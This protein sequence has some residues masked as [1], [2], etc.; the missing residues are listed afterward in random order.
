MTPSLTL[1]F[2]ESPPDQPIFDSNIEHRYVSGSSIE[3]QHSSPMP[4]PGSAAQTELYKIFPSPGDLPAGTIPD[5]PGP[6]QRAFDRDPA[7]HVHW[8][9]ASPTS[10][11]GCVPSAPVLTPL[12]GTTLTLEDFNPAF[13]AL[14]P[15]VASSIVQIGQE[16]PSYF[17]IL[18]N[19][20][21]IMDPMH[22]VEL[23]ASGVDGLNGLACIKLAANYG[24]TDDNGTFA[25]TDTNLHTTIANN[26]NVEELR[27]EYGDSKLQDTV[28]TLKVTQHQ[29]TLALR[30]KQQNSDTQSRVRKDSAFNKDWDTSSNQ[31][32][33]ITMPEIIPEHRIPSQSRQVGNTAR[34]S[35]SSFLNEGYKGTGDEDIPTANI[36]WDSLADSPH[37]VPRKNTWSPHSSLYDGTGYGDDD[38]APTIPTR[39]ADY[40]MKSVCPQFR[41]HSII[42][43]PP[44]LVEGD[45][46]S[47]EIFTQPLKYE[48]YSEY[49]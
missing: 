25:S 31:F 42:V 49:V 35:L 34:S 16:N 11:E 13:V 6:L 44:L 43:S 19:E 32:S 36:V 22:D 37:Y 24:D 23:R 3:V 38:I 15:S 2:E 28:C 21:S 14:P 47:K 29:R 12:P 46:P 17:D 33:A 9:N 45:G 27:R 10:M 26:G 4:V 8:Q 39:K 7:N 48:P 40:G 41:P 5:T 20:Q 1:N 30:P 18:I